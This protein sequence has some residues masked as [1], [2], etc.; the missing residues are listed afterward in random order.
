MF[1][2][3][4]RDTPMTDASFDELVAQADAALASAGARPR[5]AVPSIDD[6]VTWGKHKGVTYREMAAKNPGYAL[7][8]ASTIPG[9]KGQLCAEALAVR[10]GVIE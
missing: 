7:W 6:P 5:W 1:G 3:D 9:L 4:P 2:D 10:L 8:A